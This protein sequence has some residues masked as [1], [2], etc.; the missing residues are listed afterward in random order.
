MIFHTAKIDGAEGEDKIKIQGGNEG[1]GEW[2][3]WYEN[4]VY[5]ILCMYVQKFRNCLK[6][7]QLLIH[8]DFLFS[9]SY[10]IISK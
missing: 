10:N 6:N 8:L 1:L 5:E 4:E 3:L 9:P 2:G 7:F